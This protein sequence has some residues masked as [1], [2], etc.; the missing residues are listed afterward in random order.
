[1]KFSIF[2]TK[3][4]HITSW[5]VLQATNTLYGIEVRKVT[6]TDSKWT[7]I[8]QDSPTSIRTT[9]TTRLEHTLS[10]R[11]VFCRGENEQTDCCE[12]SISCSEICVEL[13]HNIVLVHIS[14]LIASIPISQAQKTLSSG[15]LSVWGFIQWGIFCLLHL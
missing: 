10:P 11:Q 12:C 2:C 15:I 9:N 8:I 13:H 3:S 1:M 5:W 6:R 14:V 4:K 7:E